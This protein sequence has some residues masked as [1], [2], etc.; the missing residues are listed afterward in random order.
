MQRNFLE[1]PWAAPV[2]YQAAGGLLGGIREVMDMCLEGLAARARQYAP[3]ERIPQLTAPYVASIERGQ[4]VPQESDLHAF[5]SALGLHS[6][7]L[8][9]VFGYKKMP[10]GRWMSA[11]DIATELMGRRPTPMNAQQ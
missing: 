11:E 9:D 4:A 7:Y 5:E 3:S 1:P 2:N 8:L 6:G 10:D